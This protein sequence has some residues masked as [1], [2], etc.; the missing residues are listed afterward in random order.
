MKMLYMVGYYATDNM[1]NAQYRAFVEEVGIANHNILDYYP[2]GKQRAIESEGLRTHLHLYS[3][4]PYESRKEAQR[5][6]SEFNQRVQR[7][8][9]YAYGV[10]VNRLL[11]S[12]S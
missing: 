5:V 12:L 6:A 8:G 9:S 4:I 1:V 3:L 11:K 10:D 2:K 7:N